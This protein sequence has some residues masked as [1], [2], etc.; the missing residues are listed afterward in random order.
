MTEDKY[1]VVE[2]SA[3]VGS[4][5]LTLYVRALE[6]DTDV[7]VEIDDRV[8]VAKDITLEEAKDAI[9]LLGRALYLER[10]RR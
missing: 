4:P 3:L 1:L 7:L 6:D 2:V 8:Q 10:L 9:V 5:L